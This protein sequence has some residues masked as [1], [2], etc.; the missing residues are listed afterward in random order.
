MLTLT[1]TCMLFIFLIHQNMLG[2]WI[3]SILSLGVS[4]YGSGSG[5]ITFSI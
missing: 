3:G 4:E 1:Q 2:L 5:V